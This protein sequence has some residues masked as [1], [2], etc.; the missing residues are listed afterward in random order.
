[1]LFL[2]IESSE[3]QLSKLTAFYM[4]NTVSLGP[5]L[6]LLKILSKCLQLYIGYYLKGNL[7]KVSYIL[8]EYK[9]VYWLPATNIDRNSVKFEFQF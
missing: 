9:F 5:G 8:V 1:M 4:A 3:A 2:L 7:K 6:E